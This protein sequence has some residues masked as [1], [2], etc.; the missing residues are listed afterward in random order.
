VRRLVRLLV[1]TLALAACRGEEP[2]PPPAP[3][4]PAIATSADPAGRT[5]VATVNGQPVFGDCVAAQAAADGIDRDA[6][7]ARCVDFELLAQEAIRRGLLAD[8]EVLAARR[9]EMV[10]ALVETEFAPT[11]DDP[12]DISDEELRRLWDRIG[13]HR[14]YNRPELRRATYCRAPFTEG[15]TARGSPE[16]EQAR[17]LAESMYAALSTMRD[18]E[19]KRF[20]ALCWMVSGGKPVKTTATPTRP[21]LRD[22]RTDGPR[23]YA[24]SFAEA[25]F[26]VARVGGVSRPTRTNWGW[27]VVLVTEVVPAQSRTFEEVA[28][29]VRE[30]LLTHPE[31]AVFRNARFEAWIG[32]YLQAARVEVFPDNLPDDHALAQTSGTSAEAER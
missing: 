20:A 32:R 9:T 15:K 18:L 17:K 2:A 1:S 13:L 8:R 11:L 12:S 30:E 4:A 31:T 21:F 7:L 6:A 14:R 27:D 10:R 26:S 25:A 3:S 22:G 23:P 16:D 29:E 5:I 24:A 28:P 19:P